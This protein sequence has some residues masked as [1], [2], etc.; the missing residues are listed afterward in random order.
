MFVHSWHKQMRKSILSLGHSQRHCTYSAWYAF[1]PS[2]GQGYG[3]QLLQH[4]FSFYRSQ[5]PQCWLLVAPTVPA[6]VRVVR[7]YTSLEQGMQ[8][9]LPLPLIFFYQTLHTLSVLS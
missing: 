6:S 9:V 8:S 3:K 7:L 5:V 1:Y 2:S 4:S